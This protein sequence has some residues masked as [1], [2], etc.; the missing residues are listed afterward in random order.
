MIAADSTYRFRELSQ[1]LQRLI[2]LMQEINFGRITFHVRSGEPDS[3]RPWH[4]RRTVKL[5]GS[6]NGPRPEAGL[7]DFSLRQEQAA[8][9]TALS[10]TGDDV[11]VTVEVR[12]GLP[13]LVEFEQDHQAE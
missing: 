4:T 9:V 10:H 2:R 1:P 13:F 3:R 12:H 11:C 7:T 8:L 5:A 6:E